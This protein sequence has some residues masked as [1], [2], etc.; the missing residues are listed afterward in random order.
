MEFEPVAVLGGV[1]PPHWFPSPFGVMEFE[2]VSQ[3]VC[4]IH[5]RFPSPFGVM[6]FELFEAGSPLVSV[7][8]VSVPFRGN[9]I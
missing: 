6:E 9:G 3:D 7:Y 8:K 2:R 5:I 4:P 1:H